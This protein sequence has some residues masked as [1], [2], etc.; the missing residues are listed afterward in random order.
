MPEEGV[1]SGTGGAA[2]AI[3]RDAISLSV[4][5]HN[6]AAPRYLRNDWMD[7]QS[8]RR[9][10]LASEAAMVCQYLAPETRLECEVA[11]AIPKF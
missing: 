2:V 4:L 10:M 6:D 3:W 9:A 1:L 8:V 5:L 11:P 7:V